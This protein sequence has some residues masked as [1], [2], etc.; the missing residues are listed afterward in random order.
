MAMKKELFYDSNSGCK[1]KFNDGKTIDF[2]KKFLCWFTESPVI[3]QMTFG[4]LGEDI[5]EIKDFDHDTFKLFLDCALGFVDLT[6]ENAVEIFP[7]ACK[8]FAMNCIEKCIEVLKPQELSENVCHALNMSLFYDQP[9]LLSVIKEFLVTGKTKG[10]DDI[11]RNRFLNNNKK[12]LF[13]HEL[14][15]NEKLLFLLSTDSLLEVIK[16]IDMDSCL[17]N[18]IISWCSNYLKDNNKPENIKSLI[19]KLGIMSHINIKLFE[20]ADLLFEFTKTDLGKIFFTTEQICEY[21]L[22]SKITACFNCDYCPHCGDLCGGS[23]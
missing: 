21:F 19:E 8:Y 22:N 7:V 23:C 10:T 3:Y 12:D 11:F 5:I 20:S 6:S 4:P 18:A 17:F 2:E 1:F 15:K 13:I 16:L 14:I 9:K